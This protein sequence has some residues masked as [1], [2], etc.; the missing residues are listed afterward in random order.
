VADGP[1]NRGAKNRFPTPQLSR[2]HKPPAK[3]K[4]VDHPQTSTPSC[5]AGTPSS[6]RCYAS[7]QVPVQDLCAAFFRP[8]CQLAISRRGS[9]VSD[10]PAQPHLLKLCDEMLQPHVFLDPGLA[11]FHHPSASLQD[12]IHRIANN[13]HLILLQSVDQI[14]RVLLLRVPAISTSGDS[15]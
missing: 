14:A 4:L 3:V 7:S 1:I 8:L 10:S 11:A 13:P 5:V 12:L 2:T 15:V 9:A 6:Q